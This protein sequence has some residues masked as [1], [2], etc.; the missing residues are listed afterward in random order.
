M[1]VVDASIV[2]ALLVEPDRLLDDVGISGATSQTWAP[3]LVDAEVGHVIRRRVAQ[4]CL[5]PHAGAAA[6]A[7]LGLLPIRRSPHRALLA[8]AWELRDNVSFY[9]ALYVALAERLELPLLTLDR[10]LAVAPG[11]RC[12]VELL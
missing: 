6:V 4:R 10:R 1:A 12:A 7:D 9:D 8:R 3:H 5:S 11:M 2:V